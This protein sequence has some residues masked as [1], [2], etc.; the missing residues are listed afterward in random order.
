MENNILNSLVLYKSKWFSDLIDENKLSNALMTKR[1]Q[2]STTLSYI[3]GVYEGA[4]NVI[5]LL[6]S[7]LGRTVTLESNEFEWDV[8]IEHERTAT[9]RDA[10]WQGAAIASTDVPGIGLTPIQIWVD[11]KMFGPGAIVAFDDRSMGRI[12][13]AGYQDGT[14]YVYTIVCADGQPESYISPAVLAKGCQLSREGS[15]Y[16]EYSEEADIV[17]Y[18][19]PFKMKNR[20]NI[21]RLS[22]DITGSAYSTVMVIEMKAPGTGKSTKLWADYQEWV[23]MR[24]WYKTI[25]RWLYYSKHNG[26]ANGVTHLKGTNGRPVFTGAGVE[27]QIAPANIRYYTTLTL[28]TLHTFM[29]DLSFNLLDKGQRKFL[30]LTGEMGLM[31]FDRVIRD[32]ADNYTL[33]DTKFV[34]GSGQELSLGGQFITYRWLNNMEITVKHLPLFDD[35]IHNRKLHPISGRPLESY[36]FLILDIGTRD[37]EANIQKVVRKDREMVMWHTG[38]SVAPGT[39]HA[40]S[41]STLRSNAK[42][43]YAVH[44][45]AEQ[46]IMIKDPT[47]SGLL[48]CDAE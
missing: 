23:A 34:S 3:F 7:G 39:G 11:E 31:E 42:D 44:F 19:T 29:A 27:Q 33:V 13:D 37:G 35:V 32:K 18:M 8:M 40:K 41:I 16:E 17:N 26:D 43:G 24:Q 5:D 38:G 20:M 2:V 45:L 46:G 21:M 4:G 36:K 48:I 28:D 1:S 9:I 30:A 25:D 47:T 10:R 15:A 14:E 22:Y 6:T 12:M